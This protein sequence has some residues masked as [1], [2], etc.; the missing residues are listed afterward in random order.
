MALLLTVVNIILLANNVY[1]S[2]KKGVSL[3]PGLHLCDDFKV[4]NNMSWWYDW[5]MD[6]PFWHEKVSKVCPPSTDQSMPPHV[7]MIKVYNNH[8][9]LNIPVDAPY[10]LG[11]NEPN[12]KNM[13]PQQAADAWPEIEKHS[14]GKPLVSPATAGKDFHWYDEFFRLCHGCR[15]DYIA[16]HLYSCDA[17]QTMSYLQKLHHRYHKKVWLTEFACSHSTDENQQLHLMQ[18][19]LPQLEAAPYV[20]RYAWFEARI[21]HTLGNG[22]ISTAASLLHKDSS[23]L[24]T[25]GHFYNNFH[26]NGQNSHI[27]G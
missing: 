6:L 2:V 18:T 25:I 9:V 5:R 15:I 8:T 7:P 24:T 17:H 12:H 26:G 20:Y 3:Y 22:F 11:F 14:H 13:T 21:T 16:A 1:G 19:L 23:T 10:I 4:L 27:V